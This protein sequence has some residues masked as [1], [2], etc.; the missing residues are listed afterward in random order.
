M[1]NHR[2]SK[3][4]L[5][6]R[7]GINRSIAAKERDDDLALFH[8]I[9][10]RDKEFTGNLLL[11]VSDEF[12]AVMGGDKISSSPLYKIPESTPRRRGGSSDFLTADGDKSDY[13]WLLTPPGTPLFPSLEMEA[14]VT[15]FGQMENPMVRPLAA[16]KTSRL[17]DS[18]AN[19]SLKSRKSGSTSRQTTPSYAAAKKPPTTSSNS[20][21]S[22]RS[23]TPSSRSSVPAY[24]PSSRPSTRSLTPVQRSSTPAQKPSTTAQQSANPRLTQNN[25]PSGRSSSVS[26]ASSLVSRN[27]VLSQGTLPT[28]KSR[29]LQP[30]SIV[31]FSI[32][33]PPNLRTNI[34]GRATSANRGRPGAPSSAQSRTGAP[35][36]SDKPKR[37]SC[38]PSVTRGRVSNESLNGNSTKSTLQ[39]KKNSNDMQGAVA[40]VVGSKMVEKLM[41]SRRS[42]PQGK[43]EEVTNQFVGS[44][45]GTK[46][47]V[48]S[49][50]SEDSTGFGR[51]ISK[52]SLDMALRH[53]DIRGGTTSSFRPHVNNV[54]VSSLYSVRSGAIKS[55]SG[56]ISRSPITTSSNASSESSA[57]IAPDPDGSEFD[58][59]DF[60]SERGSRSSQASHQSTLHFKEDAK[61]TNWLL[62][63]ASMEDRDDLSLISDQGF[64]MLSD[65]MDDVAR[66]LTAFEYNN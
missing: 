57:P 58:D 4:S 44:T 22:S 64:E 35:I 43:L 60:G 38:S 11:P 34:P 6:L 39:T 41:N 49:V 37:Q 42:T 7:R 20:T 15:G 27:P 66:E 31:G 48:K 16:I 21:P 26:K 52:K 45:L 23:S 28:V 25:P 59:D 30:S 65:P 55:K 18:Q 5:L 36:S 56:S 29:P 51:T 19:S 17:S 2:G 47:S 24:K 12:E 46:M 53:M 63:P 40:A 8:D 50:P 1:K 9:H 33:T 54:P 32:E 62:H 3:D 13:S 10:K 61:S 14:L